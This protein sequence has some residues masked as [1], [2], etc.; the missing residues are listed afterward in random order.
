MYINSQYKSINLILCFFAG[1]IIPILIWIMIP[2]NLE[3]IAPEE[4][5]TTFKGR[6]TK[7]DTSDN[8]QSNRKTASLSKTYFTESVEA[9]NN[10]NWYTAWQKIEKAYEL[11]QENPHYLF[12]RARMLH[13]G[14]G[15]VQ[16]TVL[17][18]SIAKVQYNTLRARGDDFSV[19][20]VAVMNYWGLGT[21][22]NLNLAKE[23]FE[24]L[25]LQKYSPALTSLGSMYA[26][27][28]G[29]PVNFQLAVNYYREA[30]NNNSGLAMANLA[31]YFITSQS[32]LFNLQKGLAL[33]RR[34]AN[35]GNLQ[36]IRLFGRL[37]MFGQLIPKNSQ[38]ARMWLEKGIELSD[39]HCMY[40]FANFWIARN[41][42]LKAKEWL[43]KG[44]QQHNPSAMYTLGNLYLYGQGVIT[45]YQQARKW[46]SNA[47]N[48][49]FVQGWTALGRMHFYG[50]GVLKNYSTAYKW[51]EKAA[52][53]R[54]AQAIEFLI[55]MYSTGLGVEKNE[56]KVR[57]L[58]QLL[59]K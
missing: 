30:A 7:T 46:F 44:A 2:N 38:K 41:D 4:H 11:D 24:R 55:E 20:A 42:F 56:G 57:Q 29:T 9:Y 27:G 39:P 59:S 12:H 19:F 32:P 33:Y 10:G 51:F 8:G 26:S 45:N 16:N 17:A 50:Q 5:H 14:R 28:Q 49:N 6:S 48:H 25:S 35:L 1:A 36:A 23:L 18:Q 58:R 21:V 34:A 53:Y 13:S 22:K 52:N 40:L 47:A 43:E 3:D 37:N 54:D 31:Q 15:V